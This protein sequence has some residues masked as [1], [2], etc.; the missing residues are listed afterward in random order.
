MTPYDVPYS[1]GVEA[2]RK[3]FYIKEILR[4][5]PERVGDSN[6]YYGDVEL[7]YLRLVNDGIIFPVITP[8][9][10]EANIPDRLTASVLSETF[11]PNIQVHL[12]ATPGD[13]TSDDTVAFQAWVEEGRTQLIYGGGA[14]ELVLPPAAHSYRVSHLVIQN[15][16]DDARN[17]HMSIVAQGN[18]V[19]RPYGT[20]DGSPL[21]HI[22]A[23]SPGPTLGSGW[24]RKLSFRNITLSG[25]GDILGSTQANRLGIL[26]EQA[27]DVTF[28]N[29]WI[30]QFKAGGLHAV[31]MY[32]CNF[33][34][35]QILYCGHSTSDTDYT[36]AMELRG[37]LDQCNANHFQALHMEHCPLMLR[38]MNQSRHN[39]FSNAKFEL[40]Q[41]PDNSTL[42]P[43]YFQASLENS[44]VGSFFAAT[45]ATKAMIQTT[46][47][48]S[49]YVTNNNLRMRLILSA[50][51][52]AASSANK[53]IWFSGWDTTFVNCILNKTDGAGG[54]V[55]P[56]TLKGGCHVI[57][58]I[59]SFAD[60]GINFVRLDGSGNRVIGN[61]IHGKTGATSGAVYLLASGAT[62]TI[63]EDN[64][65]F[66]QFDT[67]LSISSSET[68]TNVFTLK[69]APT[70]TLSGSTTPSIFM[71]T[72]YLASAAAA[73]SVTNFLH[74]H[75][76]KRITIRATNAN[77]TLVHGATISLKAAVNKA[78]ASGEI[79]EL[80]ND[81]G[82]WREV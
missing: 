47:P 38:V 33:D 15:F 57:N 66:G 12:P 46:Q 37:S 50:C 61:D 59:V 11:A 74:G 43:I 18:A 81:A 69:N 60:S 71:S 21:I 7:E 75:H 23:E 16:N 4:V 24:L 8:T 53:G 29:V 73:V 13:G 9:A 26:I 48:A 35:L 19:I 44:I 39:M 45:L 3:E 14:V 32:D 82:V 36:Y 25:T 27:Q 42:P 56:F 80:L 54:S 6:L 41:L 65:L 78:L 49:Q 20:E 77:T 72:T 58:N 68:A 62:N 76:G 2:Q 70:K 40:N 55:Y 5:Q 34:R 51:T 64:Q 10:V 79:I 30:S 22:K 17:L 31:D 1:A 67:P 52:F 28:D 63:V